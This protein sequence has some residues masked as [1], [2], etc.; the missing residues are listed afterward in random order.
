MHV[1]M[2]INVQSSALF[3]HSFIS[4]HKFSFYNPTLLETAS[5]K[6]RLK[7]IESLNRLLLVLLKENVIYSH[8]NVKFIEI[9]ITLV[10]VEVFAVLFYTYCTR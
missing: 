1:C 2:Y 10:S 6:I 4:D 5:N 3:R 7:V 8:L 9:R